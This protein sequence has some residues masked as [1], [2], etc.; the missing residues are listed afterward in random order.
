MT[1]VT[2][3]IK[4]FINDSMFTNDAFGVNFTEMAIQ[5]VSTLLLFLVIRFFF[6]NHIT[7]YLEG[8][9]VQMAKEY[10]DAKEASASAQ[11]VK[12]IAEAELNK[13]R[14][15]AKD[16]IEDS[17][18]RGEKERSEI[19]LKAKKEASIVLENAKK[20]IDSEVEKARIGLNDEIVSVAVLMAEKVIKREIDEKKHQDL[21]KDITNEVMN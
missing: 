15:S 18:A 3:L 10:D 6:W 20:E 14:L 11:E 8:R 7:A 9:K 16:L 13:I 2:E 12:L 4:S 17:R 1:Y 5:I 19:V 21:V